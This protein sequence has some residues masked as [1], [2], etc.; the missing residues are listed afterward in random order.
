LVARLGPQTFRLGQPAESDYLVSRAGEVKH[1]IS[2]IAGI[3]ITNASVKDIT[4]EG[5]HGTAGSEY[6]GG[7]RGGGIYLAGC[8]NVVVSGC[9]VRKYNGD[10]ISFQRECTKVTIEDCL[11]EHN[12][13]VGLHPGSGS[14]DCV[15]RKNTLRKN[16]YVGLFVCVGVTRVLF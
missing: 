12:F 4:V 14:H 16:G 13:N 8:T 1:A 7:C 15:V 9:S 2:G 11:C 3:N 5:N 6:L 10:A